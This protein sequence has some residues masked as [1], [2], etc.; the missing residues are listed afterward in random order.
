LVR[1]NLDR[2]LHLAMNMLTFSKDRQPRVEPAQLNPIIEDAISLVRHR[3]EEKKVTIVAMLEPLPEVALDSDGIHQVTQ[4]I[5]INAIEAAPEGTGQVRV[6][7]ALC[8]GNEEIVI[9]ITDN[10]DGIPNE[11]R[12]R[13][14]DVF[15]SSKGQGGTGLGLAA[16][17]KIVTELFGRIEL[18]SEAGK[19]TTFEVFLPIHRTQVVDMERT[20]TS[21]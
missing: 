18:R 11:E 6:Q 13:I 12:E 19:S 8:E 17:Q 15:H 4:N 21:V 20:R 2:T 5:L 7:T 16:A 9:R 14:F 10:G 1:R 3:A